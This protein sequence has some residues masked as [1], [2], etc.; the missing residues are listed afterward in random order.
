MIQG[1]HDTSILDCV[2]D[3]AREKVT[4]PFILIPDYIYIS[5][6]NIS[7]QFICSLHVCFSHTSYSALDKFGFPW[8]CWYLPLISRHP[9]H[10]RSFLISQWTISND[11]LSYS[12]H[13]EVILYD[14]LIIFLPCL[15]QFCS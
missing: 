11:L 8:A 13:R 15:L 6:I 9:V 7:V 5:Q 10:I 12:T 1:Y 4:N 3:P 2:E 14:S